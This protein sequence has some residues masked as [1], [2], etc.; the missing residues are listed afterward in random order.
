MGSMTTQTVALFEGTMDNGQFGLILY[1]AVT[2]KAEVAAL[3]PEQMLIVGG[4]DT[5]AGAAFVA[6]KGRMLMAFSGGLG[7][8]LVA[9]T[10]YFTGGRD[11]RYL[12]IG[13]FLMAAFTPA[14]GK[15]R[16]DQVAD[17]FLLI[18]N[19]GVVTLKTIRPGEI[20]TAVH[21]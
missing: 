21:D 4:V 9:G 8:R 7:N 2:V 15:R 3:G 1:I 18:R 10:A 6:N 13:A 19:M 17:Q 20:V 11:H 16:M 14:F 5:V 12:V